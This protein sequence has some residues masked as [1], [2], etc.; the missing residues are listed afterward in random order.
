MVQREVMERF[1]IIGSK[2]FPVIPEECPYCESSDV[3]GIEI[4]GAYD[5][6]LLWECADCMLRMLKFS[7][8]KTMSLLKKTEELYYDMES[9]KNYYA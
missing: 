7:V 8:G 6:D 5:G 2:N 9:A 1:S 4:L 3:R